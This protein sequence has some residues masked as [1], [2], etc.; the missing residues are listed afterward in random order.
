MLRAQI[1]LAASRQFAEGD[2]QHWWHAPHRRR[3][4]HPF[5]RRPAVAAA[6]LRA[7]PARQ[8]RR[9]RCSTRCV[10]FLEGAAIPDG[11]E[12]AYYVPASAPTT[13]TV[14]E[15]CGARHRPQPACRRARP[16][17][18]GQRRLERRHEPGR[19]RRAR[20]I[21][22]ARLVPVPPGGRLRAAGARSAATTRARGAGRAP[23]AGLA[24]RRCRARRGTAQ[25]F[26]R[27]F[28][29]DGTPLGSQR[30]RRVPHRPDRA[31]LGGAVG[32]R[33]ARRCSATAMA[34]VERASGRPR[35]RP[36]P[37]ARPAA[38]A[39]RSRA[40]ATS[41]PTRRACART[42]ASTRMPACGR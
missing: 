27:A 7:L 13:A 3:R 14:Y 25:W 42:A 1:V 26:K 41:R 29:D 10:P 38:R 2:V 31:G 5:L 4:A 22:V 34:A 20:R 21:G 11:A 28:F 8:R 15:H 23:R 19:P 37:A 33:A 9:Q 40:P 12:D 16:A 32:R 24:A 17:A 36:D 6:C 30:Q 35:S 18:D 39:R